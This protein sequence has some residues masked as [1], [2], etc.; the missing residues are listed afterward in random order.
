MLNRVGASSQAMNRLSA[1]AALVV[2]VLTVAACGT[3][4]ERFERQAVVLKL[5]AETV[6]GEGFLHRVYR[7]DGVPEHAL[8]VYLG[9]DGTPYFDGF[10]ATD[11]TPRTP[12]M[13]DLLALDPAPAVYLGRPCYHGLA[14]QAP[15]SPSLW[16]S[17]RYSDRVVAS[18]TAALGSIVEE[19][20]FQRTLFSYSGTAEAEP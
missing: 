12:L 11:P 18:M 14:R 8:H 20:G 6:R 17:D 16:T 4:A 5:H 9:G 3:A 10:P 7:K 19:G 13:L 2:A 15:C 1:L